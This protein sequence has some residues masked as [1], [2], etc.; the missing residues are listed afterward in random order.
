MAS[1]QQ[2]FWKLVIDSRLLA[3]EEC[4]RL[5][6]DFGRAT[7]AEPDDTG[8]L[9]R[10][11]VAEGVL[12]RYQA[13]VL[14]AGKAGPFR[15]GDYTIMDRHGDGQ[16]K[17]VYQA[18]N[19]TSGERLLLLVVPSAAAVDPARLEAHGAESAKSDRHRRG[20]DDTDLGLAAAG[21]ARLRGTG[22]AFA[23]GRGPQS[24]A[25]N[26][27]RGS[28]SAVDQTAAEPA[29]QWAPEIPA[30][31]ARR[32]R[33]RWGP[34]LV[35]WGVGLGLIG[36]AAWVWFKVVEP[37]ETAAV[38]PQQ[39]SPTTADGQGAPVGSPA[40]QAET[41][42]V[43]EGLAVGHVAG[44][45]QPAV[46]LVEDDGETL[47]ASPTS[48][49]PLKLDY[50]PPGAEA[51]LVLRAAELAESAEGSKLIEA[52]GP[53]GQAGSAAVQAITG[54]PLGEIDE[55]Q[56]GFYP[57]DAGPVRTAFVL[58]LAASVTTEAWTE[59]WSNRTAAEHSGKHYFKAGDWAYFL[60]E[61]EGGR[62]IVV[63]APAEI[64]GVI[65]SD[66]PHLTKEME[67]LLADT[68]H[69]RHFTLIAEPFWIFGAGRAIFAGELARLADP[70]RQFL[71]DGSASG[72]GQWLDRGRSVPRAAGL[73]ANRHRPAPSGRATIV[74]NWPPCRHAWKPISPRSIRLLMERRSCCAFRGCSISCS[75]TRGPTPNI[76]RPFCAPICPAWPRRICS[77]RRIWP[78]GSNPKPGPNRLPRG[79]KNR[80]V[81]A[82][83]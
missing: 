40:G 5:H 44:A 78:S 53:A 8:A 55:L 41:A 15:L 65:D 73:S 77:W 56:I 69:D 14:L 35:G 33:R 52:I 29:Q 58:R 30:F 28:P 23:G 1:A 71:G 22:R 63:A 36:G 24:A 39:N 32:K 48:G 68:D 12:T 38:V 4:Q 25:A 60:P 81:P 21:I 17:G 67:R 51:I 27:R 19:R 54:C 7:Q 20:A 75:A 3:L 79:P 49:S 74:P 10:W 70:L 46:E 34:A 82:R 76:T 9:A 45:G 43:D 62:L 66:G 47:W 50:L 2:K 18:T 16:T 26:T 57:A 61:A 31:Q 42:P 83:L 72:S 64:E 80:P 11:L 6:A 37:V 13:R 59:R